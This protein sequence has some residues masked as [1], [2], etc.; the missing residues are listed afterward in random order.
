MIYHYLF[1]HIFSLL[2]HSSN[3]VFL[4][5]QVQYFWFY[6]LRQSQLLHQHFLLIISSHFAF[7]PFIYLHYF[8]IL[9]FLLIK[10]PFLFLIILNHLFKSTSSI[11]KLSF[12]LIELEIINT[13]RTTELHNLGNSTIPITIHILCR[14]WP[15]ST[16]LSLNFQ[17]SFILSDSFL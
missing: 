2:F 17:I 11:I 12:L 1:N 14:R 10:I 6:H 7:G 15:H 16:Y 4:E 3:L 8:V 9:H 13:F 5:I